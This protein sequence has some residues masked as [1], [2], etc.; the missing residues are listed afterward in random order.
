MGQRLT[1]LP[2]VCLDDCLDDCQTK[3]WTP[4]WTPSWGPLYVRYVLLGGIVF[5]GY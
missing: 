4:V 3:V 1:T 5:I 2:N